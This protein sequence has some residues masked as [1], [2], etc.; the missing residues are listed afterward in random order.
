MLQAA[1]INRI[2]ATV[3]LVTAIHLAV[4]ILIMLRMLLLIAWICL[5]PMNM[6]TI[7]QAC[8]ITHTIP[9][10]L[11]SKR[12]FLIK[13]NIC[14]NGDILVCETCWLQLKPMAPNM[15]IDHIRRQ[16][17]SHSICF[18]QMIRLKHP[19]LQVRCN[20]SPICIL[21][22]CGKIDFFFFAIRRLMKHKT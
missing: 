11:L 19:C 14:K 21:I 6:D 12:G 8:T 5:N 7:L 17:N 9:Y 3:Q 2:E 22:A 1:N 20:T 10:D 4:F 16:V 13:Q 18:F 15:S